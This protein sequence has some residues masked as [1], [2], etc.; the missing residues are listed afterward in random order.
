MQVRLLGP[1]DVTT[2]GLARPLPGVRRKSVLAALALH[3][4]SVV[5][6]DRLL[7][8]V[9][10]GSAGGTLNTLQ[11]HISYLRDALGD[12]SSILSSPPGYR[13]NLGTDPTDV[14]VAER[15]IE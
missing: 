8:I 3:A 5:S 2:G 10:A 14:V 7:D 15:L 12:K 9:W 4:G 1:V 6:T 11:R 13:L